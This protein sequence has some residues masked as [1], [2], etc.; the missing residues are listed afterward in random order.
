MV[1][2]EDITQFTNQQWFSGLAGFGTW[3]VQI[4]L[5]IILFAALYWVYLYTEHKIKITIF[6]IFGSIDKDK[7]KGKNLEEIKSMNVELGH[8]LKCRGKDYKEKGIK[9]FSLMLNPL[10]FHK[11]PPIPFEKRYSDGIWMLQVAK[12]DYIVVDKPTLDKTVNFYVPDPD[13]DLW[14]EV[15]EEKIR[16]RTTDEDFM[17]KQVFMTAMIIIGAFVLAGVIIWLSMSFAGN[18]INSALA[19]IDL[20]L[21]SLNNLAS[22]GGPG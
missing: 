2:P 3:L 21:P 7:L 12:D 9:K 13:L 18:S 17:K 20:M 11:M 8:P 1:Q 19:K 5:G 16:H 4:L 6:P 14:Q 10:K 22:S 15:A